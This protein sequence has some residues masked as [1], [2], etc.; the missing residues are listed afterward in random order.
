MTESSVFSLV[1]PDWAELDTARRSP[2]PF[3]LWPICGK[4][5]LAWWLDEAIRQGAR[6][7]EIF[8]SDRPHLIREWL[9]Q[10]NLW[11]RPIKVN[12]SLPP[13]S[14]DGLHDGGTLPGWTE[15]AKDVTDAVS[16]LKHWMSLQRAV[17]EKRDRN[18][19]H[20]DQEKKPG[21][22]FGPGTRIDPSVEFIGPCR[23]GPYAKVG[24][25]CRIG[26]NAFVDAGA[27][28]DEDVEVENSL[29]CADTYVGSHT[30][31]HG[32]IV[33]G[34]LLIRQ[35]DGEIVRITDR[36]ILSSLK[37][38]ER[39]GIPIRVVAFILWLVCVPLSRILAGRLREA[40]LISDGKGGNFFLAERS[41]GP[42]LMR[43]S[44]WLREVARGHLRFFGILPRTDSDWDRIPAD[45]R[46]AL[47]AVLPG[48][49]ALSDLH[50]A[51]SPADTDE[52]MHAIYQ[53]SSPAKSPLRSIL[54]IAFRNPERP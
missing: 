5:L 12:S 11:S 43:R 6:E 16:L 38:G 37:T 14:T 50:G 52:W 27:F 26:P 41:R 33:D 39:P 40:R 8:A 29:V 51:H 20:L 4:P 49:F 10:G 15:S 9:E 45:T 53:A 24:P 34:G 42:L 19:V 28:L 36:F 44:S 18:A 21:V 46:S 7:I 54:T 47:Q 1:A 3:I 17:L 2:Y 13:P 31:L 23:I 30:S 35:Q 22:W 25:G 32:V 48:V